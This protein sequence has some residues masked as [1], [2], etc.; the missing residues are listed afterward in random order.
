MLPLP[1]STDL[2]SPSYF[3]FSFFF[4]T[5][6]VPHVYL[7]I[8]SSSETLDRHLAL[9][10]LR[11]PVGLDTSKYS[12]ATD[13]AAC[14]EDKNGKAFLNSSFTSVEVTSKSDSSDASTNGLH[15]KGN[16]KGCN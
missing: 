2:Y 7:S 3:L 8:S 10:I 16:N 15:A 5:K 4:L 13:I 11:V 9:G 12:G 1:Y 14:F 6:L